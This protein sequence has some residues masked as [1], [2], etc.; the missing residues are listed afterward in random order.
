LAEKRRPK[1]SFLNLD[2][3]NFWCHDERAESKWELV[4]HNTQYGITAHKEVNSATDGSSGQRITMLRV[5]KFHAASYTLSGLR[6]RE[7]R[8][9]QVA[10]ARPQ[11]GRS[12]TLR[13]QPRR[14]V[15][16]YKRSYDNTTDRNPIQQ[17]RSWR[18]PPRAAPDRP[19]SVPNGQCAAHQRA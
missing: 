7:H 16:G 18:S 15:P 12:L 13:E 6:Y 10:A 5:A 14:V 17:Q 2:F 3:S 1:F 4:S 11:A 19:K 8:H 9:R